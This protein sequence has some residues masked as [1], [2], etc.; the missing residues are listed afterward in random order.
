MKFTANISLG[1]WANVHMW[2]CY[3]IGFTCME[4]AQARMFHSFFFFFLSIF[5]LEPNCLRLNLC[6]TNMLSKHDS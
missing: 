5:G 4:L 2:T 6:V 1:I 3:R